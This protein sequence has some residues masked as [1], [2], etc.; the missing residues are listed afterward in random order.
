MWNGLWA[1]RACGTAP[2]G[3]LR[4]EKGLQQLGVES[5]ALPVPDHPQGLL[6]GEGVL[7]DPLAGQGVVYVRQGHH[8]GPD[9]DLVALETVGIA[10]AVPA[11]VVVAG[12][13][14]GVEIGA[15][16]LHLGDLLQQG[17]AL[18]RMGLH[19]FKLFFG[20]LPGLAQDSVGD[21]DLA[22]VVHDGGQGDVVH[23]RLGK[24][25][26]QFRVGEQIMGDVVD[27]A[28]VLAGFAVAELDGGGQC[29]H[30]ALA[31]PD[32]LGGP[33]QKLCLLAVHHAAEPGT[34]LVQLYYGLH[35]PQHHIG[36]HRLADHVHDAQLV[37][38]LHHAAAG[39]RRDEEHGHV[40]R[41]IA[42]LQGAQHLDPVHLRHHHIQQ[43]G[44]QPLRAGEDLL[45]ALPAVFR[46]LDGVVGGE[47]IFQNAPVDGVIVDDQQRMGGQHR[48]VLNSS[49]VMG[50]SFA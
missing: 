24:T 38:L 22:H 29:L 15:A 21:G 45:Q 9:G 46:L 49:L 3:R 7:V 44:A 16:L 39:L 31:E 27:A 28:Y 4:S 34:G 6:A 17:R 26:P 1:L 37:G 14:A 40:L 20:E 10:P 41:Q 23:I 32:D 2:A 30:H 43:D 25:V 47:N 18:D 13:V 36:D 12:D 5:A 19:D 11:L 35:P 50:D 33:L 42:V 8:L 48:S